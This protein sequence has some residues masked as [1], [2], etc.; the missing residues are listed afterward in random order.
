MDEVLYCLHIYRVYD[1]KSYSIIIFLGGLLL[2][3]VLG[4]DA[5]L[6]AECEWW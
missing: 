2:V 5:S 3:S 1:A 4:K 6:E